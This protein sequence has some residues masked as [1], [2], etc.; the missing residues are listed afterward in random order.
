M[1]FKRLLKLSDWPDV[2]SSWQTMMPLHFALR[3][4]RLRMSVATTTPARR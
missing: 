1:L 3:D 4:G 2:Q